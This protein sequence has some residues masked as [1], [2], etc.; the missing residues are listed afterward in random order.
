MA[1]L[2]RLYVPGCA[3]HVIQRGNN[4]AACFHSDSDYKAYLIFLQEAAQANDV[5]VH[6]FVLMTNHVHLLVSPQNKDGVPDMMQ[7]LGRRY[8]QRFN[9]MH[10]RTGTLWE[11]RY[12]STLVDSER[13]LLAVYRYIELNPVRAKMV[14]HA[15]DYKWSS[16]RF[17]AMG[18]PTKLI[19]PHSEYLG[20]GLAEE[21]RR[22]AYRQLF[23]NEMSSQ[24]LSDIRTSTNK[25]WVLGSESFQKHVESLAGRR[26]SGS[27]RGGD[28]R[29]EKFRQSRS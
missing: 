13:Y 11:G 2:P 12:K 1:R 10:K 29:S 15:K 19:S 22:L 28:R 8:V 3:H 18:K 26:A 21:Q 6:A 17:N 20:L 23:K 4:R 24:F 5:A 14:V 16:Y 7:A 9:Y 27:S 25:G